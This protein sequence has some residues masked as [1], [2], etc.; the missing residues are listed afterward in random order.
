MQ[1]FRAYL[2]QITETTN[3]FHSYQGNFFNYCLYELEVFHTVY[4]VLALEKTRSTTYNLFAAIIFE[5]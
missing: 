4:V 5:L 1:N 3:R 2:T